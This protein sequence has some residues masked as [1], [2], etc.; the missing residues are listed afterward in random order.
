MS[1]K[2]SWGTRT[3]VS[4]RCRCQDDRT[5]GGARLHHPTWLRLRVSAGAA[6][7]PS[8]PQPRRGLVHLYFRLRGPLGVDQQVIEYRLLLALRS[9]W[10][11]GRQWLGGRHIWPTNCWGRTTTASRGGQASAATPPLI[12]GKGVELTRGGKEML[13]WNPLSRWDNLSLVLRYNLHSGLGT[14]PVY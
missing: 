3:P 7:A 10:I 4:S 12:P 14:L 6:P 8:W 1:E 2:P 5:S 13:S 11:H 9:A